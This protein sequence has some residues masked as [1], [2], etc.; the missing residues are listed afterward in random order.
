MRSFSA[1]SWDDLIRRVVAVDDMACPGVTLGGV[2]GSG[3]VSP[4]VALGGVASPGVALGGVAGPDVAFG[5]VVCAG[6]SLD[7][8]GVVGRGMVDRDGGFLG[9]GLENLPLSVPFSKILPPSSR[10]LGGRDPMLGLASLTADEDSRASSS[11]RICRTL[12]V[13]TSWGR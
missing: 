8:S 1:L 9:T 5:A 7:W 3:V 6:M 11:F 2:A 4:D 10:G 13:G 12:G